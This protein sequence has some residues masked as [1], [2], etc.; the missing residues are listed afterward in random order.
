[1][2]GPSRLRDLLFGRR[3]GLAGALLRG[4]L[5]L[6]EIPYGVVVRARNRA[7]DT[8][9]R[10]PHQVPVPVVSVGNIT[11]G[12][13]GK[14][15]L[16][17][18]IVRWARAHGQRVGVV[19]RGYGAGPDPR[20][21]EA[22]E[23]ELALP[24]LPHV[25]DPDRVRGARRA[26]RQFGCQWLVLD[27]GF[28]HRRLARNLDLVLIDGLEPFGYGHLV[29]RGTLR[30]PLAGLCR[31]DMLILSRADMLVP[32]QRAA[33]R[34]RLAEYAPG[35]GWAEV[36]HAPKAL[37][38]ASAEQAALASLA[39]NPVAAFCGVGNPAAFR[40]TLE[41]LGWRVIALREFA[42]HYRY[43]KADIQSLIAWANRLD[44]AAV[45]CTRKDLV[46]LGIDRLGD[47]P[48]WA[49][50]IG[51]EFLAGQPLLEGRLAA[52]VAPS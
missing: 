14:T 20:N 28:Q 39:G 10:R 11:L 29:P 4:G 42:D 23:L 33:I 3:G 1:M 48:L 7:Y 43:K 52:L 5:R 36:V 21:D 18:W 26:I 2:F 15:P 50:T 45:V 16:V 25:Q 35:A 46:K 17:E 22:M 13:T 47:R 38:N 12:G 41:I 30:E 51:L 6:A 34:R 24:G 31:A 49:V 9:L 37:I 40:K 44:V 8:R 27:D 32:A 19:S